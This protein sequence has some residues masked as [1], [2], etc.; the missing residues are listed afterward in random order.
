MRIETP[1]KIAISPDVL[2]P[3]HP[4]APRARGGDRG[5]PHERAPHL[6]DDGV[7]R[8]FS[9]AGF[10]NWFRAR[11]DEAGLT[12][13]SAHGLRKAMATRLADEG[14]AAHEIMAVTGHQ[15][16]EEAERYSRAASRSN[17]ATSAMAKLGKG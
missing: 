17:L 8:P 13:C 4:A 5:R 6:H 14:A 11:R 10:E 12:H 7:R 9:V 16:L 3:G 2:A 1:L 15:S